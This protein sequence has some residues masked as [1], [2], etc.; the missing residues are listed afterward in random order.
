[1]ENSYVERHEESG[2][3][4]LGGERERDDWASKILV[5]ARVAYT[6]P[7]CHRRRVERGEGAPAG[8]NVYGGYELLQARN[9]V[10]AITIQD[11][12]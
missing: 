12:E 5:V 4:M 8:R 7:S 1:M 10:N 6:R 9:N 11:C 2:G 3:V